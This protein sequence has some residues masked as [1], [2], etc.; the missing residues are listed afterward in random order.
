MQEP[1]LCWGRYQYKYKLSGVQRDMASLDLYR[2]RG[3]YY[4]NVGVVLAKAGKTLLQESKNRLLDMEHEE[5]TASS[6][7]ATLVRTLRKIKRF[8]IAA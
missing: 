5:G 1:H 8:R 6:I 3:A 7:G 4:R 2:G